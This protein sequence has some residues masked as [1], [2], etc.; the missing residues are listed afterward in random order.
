[1]DGEKHPSNPV[2]LRKQER[3]LKKDY[4]YPTLVNDG[5]QRAPRNSVAGVGFD[6]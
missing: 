2:S 3:K 4:G 5:V 1:M 6:S